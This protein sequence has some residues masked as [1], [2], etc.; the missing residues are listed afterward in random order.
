MP[1]VHLEQERLPGPT[2]FSG[3]T[4]SLMPCFQWAGLWI[5]TTCASGCPYLLPFGLTVIPIKDR[6]I[7]NSSQENGWQLVSLSD[8][9]WTG[10]AAPDG[11]IALSW[12]SYG[13]QDVLSER[14][15]LQ[16]HL[17]V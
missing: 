9:A 1:S 14:V 12:N 10:L 7:C 4:T 5:E 16:H 13:A 6:H 2:A 3:L 15:L 17:Y 8:T 11:L